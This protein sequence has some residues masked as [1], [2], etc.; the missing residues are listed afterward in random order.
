MSGNL[1]IT[2]DEIEEY[3][4]TEYLP[5]S[6]TDLN[7]GG[8]IRIAIE[9][10]DV[11]THPSKSYLQFT[12]RLTKADGTAYADADLVSL[13]NDAMMFLFNEIRLSLA[14]TTIETSRICGQSNTMLKAAL[15]E[16][17]PQDLASGWSKDTSADAA[18]TN[19][20]FAARQ[21]WVITSPA[22]KGSFQFIVP[23]SDIFGF[24]A[25]YEQLLYGM[26]QELVLVRKTDSDAVFRAAAADAA[27]I[28]LSKI[29]WMMPHVTPNLT[30]K[31]ELLELIESK[32]VLPVEFRRRQSET[33]S[34]AQSTELDWIL[35]VKSSS[36]KP[37]YVLVAF[38]TDRANDET[39]N[40]AIF[41]HCDLTSLSLFLSS[42]KYPKTDYKLDW[43]KNGFSRSYDDFVNFKS[44]YYDVDSLLVKPGVGPSDYK[45]LFPIFVVDCSKQSER[46]KN[47]TITM[48]INA[49]FK[50]AVPA[51]TRAFA[52]CISDRLCKFQS[53]GN[54]FSVLY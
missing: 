23:L 30:K 43:D 45:S 48:R 31:M 46:L 3:E 10:Q 34:V 47:T 5:I 14:G 50:N 24:A 35:S 11:F 12:G 19:L 15:K 8:E 51:N 16:A 4:F 7:G 53:D 44:S 20:G 18:L 26:R 9:T 52:C 21:S 38:Q 33:V 40:P 27:K 42:T 1:N 41:D 37:R 29:S 32:A 39:K 36:E 49:T 2:G 17:G 22:T 6:G 13:T 25:D 54:K 28:T